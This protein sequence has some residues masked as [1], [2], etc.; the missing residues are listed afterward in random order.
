MELTKR[1]CDLVVGDVVY[2]GSEDTEFSILDA[3][4]VESRPVWHADKQSMQLE[5][6]IDF[7]LLSDLFEGWD[8]FGANDQLR[9]VTQA[10]YKAL[11]NG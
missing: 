4:E 2:F 9:V 6:Q 7:L 10:Q 3:G 5:D 8:R 1:A 11:H